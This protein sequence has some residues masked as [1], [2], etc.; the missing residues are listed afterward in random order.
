MKNIKIEDL[1]DIAHDAGRVI[2]DIYNSE[3]FDVEIKDDR[4]PLTK[5]D[6]ESHNIIKSGIEKVYSSIPMISEEGKNIPYE[7]RLQVILAVEGIP[8]TSQADQSSVN[9]ARCR[10]RQL[11][12]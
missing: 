1:I 8:G 7:D 9:L 4:S 2:M 11:A 12:L 10:V 6:K 3:Q 5:A